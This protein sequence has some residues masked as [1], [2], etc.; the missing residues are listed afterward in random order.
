MIEE[1]DVDT[2]SSSLKN[3]KKKRKKLNQVHSNERR[4]ELTMKKIRG[5]PT[6]RQVQAQLLAS[7]LSFEPGQVLSSQSPF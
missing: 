3:G 2:A 1:D 4:A 5:L 6:G 7:W